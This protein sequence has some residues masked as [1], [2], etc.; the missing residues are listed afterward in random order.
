MCPGTADLLNWI[1]R[2]LPIVPSVDTAGQQVPC[3]PRAYGETPA[4]DRALQV[5]GTPILLFPLTET[6]L[7]C[8]SVSRGSQRHVSGSR[9]S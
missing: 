8:I 4:Q 2:T 9:E 1:K 3:S 5:L 6:Y 7:R